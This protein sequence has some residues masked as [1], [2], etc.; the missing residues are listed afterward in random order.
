ME[1]FLP[2]DDALGMLINSKANEL[3]SSMQT[4]DADSLGMPYHCLYY[5]KASHTKRLFFSIET[6]AHLLYRSIKLKGKEP[7][8][9]ILMDYGAGVGTLFL[10]AKAIGCKTVIYSDHLEDWKQSA[11]LIANALNIHIDYYIVGDIDACLHYLDEAGI[12]CDIITS[13]NVLEHIYKLDQFYSAIQAKQPSAIVYSSTTANNCNPAAVIKHMLWHRKW[14]KVY[15]GKRLKMI[16]QMA[17]G[18]LPFRKNKLAKATRG[19]AGKDLAD[20]VEQFRQNGKLPNIRRVRSNTCDPDN[21]VWAENLLRLQQ[22]RELIDENKFRISFVPGFW[23]TH[24]KS[25]YKNRVSSILNKM[26]S[27]GGKTAMMLAPFIYVIAT[28]KNVS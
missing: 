21:G 20:T 12:V 28:P 2:H 5:F 8:N 18:M 22:Y 15:R 23:D 1:R 6:S 10:L 26:I 3:L 14:E 9:T 17:P 7:A 27:R 25:R 16:E 19:L 4:L 24:Y 11:A 13:R